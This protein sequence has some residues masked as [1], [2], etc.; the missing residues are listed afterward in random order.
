[1][2][3][4]LAPVATVT[5]LAVPAVV[6][7]AQHLVPSLD[8]VLHAPGTHVAVVAGISTVAA[9]VALGA[10]V[11]AVRRRRGEPLLL[12]AG[13][14][15]LAVLFAGHGLSTPGVLSRPGNPWVVRLPVRRAAPRRGVRRLVQRF[16]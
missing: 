1:M 16:V 7:T 12:A 4:P 10:A 14:L 3:V 6:V 2:R 15:W 5:A 11:P 8:P 9:A 13:C